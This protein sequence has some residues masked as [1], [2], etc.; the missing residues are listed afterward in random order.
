[1][2]GKKAY[3]K[4]TLLLIGYFNSKNRELFSLHM[5]MC[6]ISGGEK[7]KTA[8]EKTFEGKKIP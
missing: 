5:K 3:N 2:V 8:N 1:M 7:E 6:K 4:V